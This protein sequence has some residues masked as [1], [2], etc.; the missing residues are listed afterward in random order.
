MGF[1]SCLPRAQP[2]A[3]GRRD[4][5]VKR[6]T[7]REVMLP[8]ALVVLAVQVIGC[9]DDGESDSASTYYFVTHGP[10]TDVGFWGDVLGGATATATQLGVGLVALHPAVETTGEALNSLMRQAVEAEPTGIVGTLWGDGMTAIIRDANQ[11]NVPVA[12][13][14]VYPDP[15]EYAASPG[16]DVSAAASESEALFVLYSGQNDAVAAVDVT[17]GMVCHAS[18]GTLINSAGECADGE[19]RAA[20]WSQLQSN[21]AIVGVCIVHQE[22]ASVLTRCATFRERLTQH[23][24]LA[25]TA[26][27]E[28]SW[29]ESV[30]GAG[31]A[32]IEAFFAGLDTATVATILVLSNGPGG[33]APYMAAA[34]DQA[35]VD[36]ITVGTFDT[37][38]TICAALQNGRIAF[39]S[40]QGQKVQGAAALEYLH[41]YVTGGV[42]PESGRNPGG[43][44]EPR[45]TRSE[46]G[47]PWFKT[48]PDLL[49]RCP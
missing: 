32:A 28:I 40:S 10:T 34:I 27:Y 37:S 30:A 12:A 13:V 35:T 41:Q 47:Y 8:V 39:A 43:A 24:G 31:K 19:T 6:A 2:R 36:M 7:R 1:A 14:N 11:R 26:V 4:P 3:V 45:W 15:A 29:D 16:G 25:S 46:D 42:L 23:Y 48:G 44:D 5:C 38:D 9:S 33:A 49:S 22:A 18:T 20:A 21:G 17:D